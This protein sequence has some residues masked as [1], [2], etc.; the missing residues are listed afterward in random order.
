MFKHSAGFKRFVFVVAVTG[1]LFI[2][3]PNA[4]GSPVSQF[5]DSGTV[6][7]MD[8]VTRDETGL[9]VSELMESVIEGE[10]IFS[11]ERIVKWLGDTFLTEVK[12]CIGLMKPVM[13]AVIM[14]A[15]LKTV[16]SSFKSKTVSELSFYVCYM[17]MIFVITE[18][19]ALTGELVKDSLAGL[20]NIVVASMP[21]FY[22][23]M[24][25]SGQYT[26]AFVAG[27][28]V[29]G[30]AGAMA[31]FAR[32]V[33]LPAISLGMTF[34][35]VNNITERERIGKL[36]QLIVKGVRWM[37]KTISVSFMA[38]LSLQKIGAS[39]ADKAAGK[40]VKAV[41][42][43]VPVV[44]DVLGGAIDTAAA[45]TGAVKSSYLVAV[46]VVIGIACLIP[47]IKVFAVMIM[48]KLMA[49]LT[50]PIGE[51]RFIKCINSAGDNIG[52]MLSTLFTAMVM[53]MF[54]AIILAGLL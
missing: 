43:A 7:E 54:A 52:L 9:R 16:S 30:A 27:P 40:T 48:F 26:S 20:G 38:L 12:E 14:S 21:V 5:K 32:A 2:S 34:E 1:M 13:V 15:L 41:M 36:S 47:L 53:F 22:T 19:F 18:M 39:A 10:N 46:I 37:L 8:K 17:V 35:I 6:K 50:E 11:P 42:G 24:A 25:A 4:F 45:M 28:F 44:G 49:V 33:I 23:I 3:A 29:A 51:K 31:G